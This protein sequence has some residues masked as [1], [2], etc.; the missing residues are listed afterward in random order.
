M[1]NAIDPNLVLD[2][3]GTP[4]LSFGSF[5]NG[6]KLVKMDTS[7]TRIAEPEEWHTDRRAPPLL[8]AR[9][10]RRRGLRQP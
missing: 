5:W 8:E 6:I 2:E 10:A 4:W 7:L 9:R 3:D 1:W